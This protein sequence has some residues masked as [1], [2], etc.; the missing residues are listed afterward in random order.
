MDIRRI[1]QYSL[2]LLLVAGMAAHAHVGTRQD[3]QG[4]IA[5]QG[6]LVPTTEPGTIFLA[7][8]VSSTG[9]GTAETHV[10]S[11]KAA[12]RHS[13]P[14]LLDYFAGYAGQ[15]ARVIVTTYN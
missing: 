12:R 15:E 3:Q 13:P 2:S 6:S 1:G 4:Y 8:P 9:D 5:F 14:E 11:L 10:E 7:G